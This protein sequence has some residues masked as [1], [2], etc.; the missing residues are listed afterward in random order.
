MKEPRRNLQSGVRHPSA[1]V[2]IRWGK[3]TDKHLLSIPFMPPLHLMFSDV[4]NHFR[5]L[6]FSLVL[7]HI[8]GL[9]S[10]HEYGFQ[11]PEL[12]AA[13]TFP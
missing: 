10:A 11:I 6:A 1:Q 3:V 12:I 2:S 7:T 8:P 5:S 13:S 4:I 9:C